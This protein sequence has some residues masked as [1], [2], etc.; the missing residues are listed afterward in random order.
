[1]ERRQ[2]NNGLTMT[3]FRPQQSDHARCVR[4][5]A[6]A[7]T[8]QIHVTNCA[9]KLHSHFHEARKIVCNNL[10]RAVQA[11]VMQLPLYAKQALPLVKTRFLR[12]ANSSPKTARSPAR[13]SRNRRET[14]GKKSGE[15]ISRHVRATSRQWPDSGSSNAAE[16]L[17]R[18]LA[19]RL[20]LRRTWPRNSR[21]TS[22]KMTR[23]NPA[24]MFS[25]IPL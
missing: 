24:V 19:R 7:G 6:Y 18:Q 4:R 1:M 9:A 12:L 14:S 22:R 21:K 16:R 5:K 2:R 20:A 10:S 11:R 3:T 25:T 8:L 23:Q 15:Y 17:S 13:R